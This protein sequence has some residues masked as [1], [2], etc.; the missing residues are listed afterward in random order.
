MPGR[1]STS[2]GDFRFVHVHVGAQ[3]RRR[4]E[5]LGLSQMRLAQAAGVTYQLIQRYER[6]IVGV[7]ISRLSSNFVLG[8]MYGSFRKS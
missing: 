8:G 4:R 2:K 7:C 5:Q 3:L 1:R 6:G